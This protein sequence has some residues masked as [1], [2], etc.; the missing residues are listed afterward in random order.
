MYE[1]SPQHPVLCHP[2]SVFLL[3]CEKQIFTITQNK[4]KIMTVYVLSFLFQFLDSGME[5][6]QYIRFVISEGQRKTKILSVYDKGAPLTDT[7]GH[8]GQSPSDGIG[9]KVQ[10]FG[11]WLCFRHQV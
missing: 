7:C 4:N 10:R 5:E 1:L 3:H 6:C 9:L 8:C 2:R 11:S